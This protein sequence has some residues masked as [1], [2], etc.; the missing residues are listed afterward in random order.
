VNWDHCTIQRDGL[1]ANLDNFLVLQL[2][3]DSLKHPVF[4][5]TVHAGIDGMPIPK[6]LGQPTPLTA[7]L[8]N[9]Q[10]GIEYLPIT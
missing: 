10:N 3:E 7:M 4:G 1:D 8:C 9:V 2:G 5:P 6:V